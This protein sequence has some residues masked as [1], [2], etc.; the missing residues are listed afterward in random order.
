MSK[1]QRILSK[2]QEG[3]KSKESKEKYLDIL[4]QR[5]EDN[6]KAL[7]RLF[8][9]LILSA[10][11]FPL[12]ADTKIAEISIGPFKI[13]DSDIALAIIPTIF[14]YA[15]YKYLL[16]WFDFVE[17]K[18]TYRLLT[19]NY[20]GFEYDSFLNDRLNPFSVVDSISRHH[21]QEKFDMIGCL[22][23]LLW[24]PTAFVLI[25]LPFATEFY[26]IK[27]TFEIVLPTSLIDWTVVIIPILIALFTILSLIQ[28]I[29]NDLKN[30]KDKKGEKAST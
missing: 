5:M 13:I 14:T 16:I 28:V 9:V 20:F 17:Q 15:Y 22:S 3:L 29:K 21:T 1:D 30:S 24:I 6:R 25:F 12:I 10:I 7:G 23:Y 19:T 2:I 8:I 4:N 18:R 26:L 11:A 27:R